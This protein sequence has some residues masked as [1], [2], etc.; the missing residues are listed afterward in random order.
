MAFTQPVVV[1]DRKRRTLS[2]FRN[3]KLRAFLDVMMLTDR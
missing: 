1:V 2:V 3:K